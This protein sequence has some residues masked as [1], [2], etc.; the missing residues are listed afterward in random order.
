MQKN[1]RKDFRFS[2]GTVIPAGAKIGTVTLALHRDSK[3]YENPDVFDGFR[4]FQKEPSNSKPSTLV[5][6]AVNH[7]VFGH[8]RHPW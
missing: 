8:G 6:T 4:F 7:H 2:D 5:N 3:V 1:A